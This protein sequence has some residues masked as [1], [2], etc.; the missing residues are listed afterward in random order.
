MTREERI[1]AV[2]IVNFLAMEGRVKDTGKL[3]LCS[4]PQ[5][6]FVV[7]IERIDGAW[8]N[9]IDLAILKAFHCSLP[10]QAIDRF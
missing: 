10:L 2:A 9:W 8:G 6:M 1:A 7:L 4:G 5:N 3:Y